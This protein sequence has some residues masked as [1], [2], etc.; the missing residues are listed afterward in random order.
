M[1]G[2]VERLVRGGIEEALPKRHH[3]LVHTATVKVAGENHFILKLLVLVDGRL[4]V[5]SSLGTCIAP[6]LV[7]GAM[8]VR[9]EDGRVRSLL[10]QPHP[11]HEPVT[12]LVLHHRI[13]NNP[14][15]TD[16]LDSTI[17]NCR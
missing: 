15:R 12:P 8:C 3:R 2:P 16:L 5:G 11:I 13:M 17:T 7:Q 10:S 4:V 9:K 1:V 14:P 6:A